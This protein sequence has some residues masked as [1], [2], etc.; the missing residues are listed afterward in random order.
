MSA[1]TLADASALL[2]QRASIFRKVAAVNL[3]LGTTDEATAMAQVGAAIVIEGC[4]SDIDDLASG[5]P[6]P[7]MDPD[8]ALKIALAGALT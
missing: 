4:A 5:R 8:L 2:R 1:P 3:A 7:P 6:A